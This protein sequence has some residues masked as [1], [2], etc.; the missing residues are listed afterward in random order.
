MQ[1]AAQARLYD[2]FLHPVQKNNHTGSV[3]S[4][5][6][7]RA[8]EMSGTS[9]DGESVLP[10]FNSFLSALDTEHKEGAVH[11]SGFDEKGRSKARVWYNAIP[12]LESGGYVLN[13]NFFYVSSS[14]DIVRWES[15]CQTIPVS[16]TI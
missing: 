1:W 12:H 3:S 13:Y 8:K 16:L 15:N 6:G 2:R 14:E 7:K 4:L 11:G 10:L 5:L 9:G